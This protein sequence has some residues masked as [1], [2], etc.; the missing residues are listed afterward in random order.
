MVKKQLSCAFCT[1]HM[2]KIGRNGSNG[3]FTVFQFY[4]MLMKQI[5]FVG[6]SLGFH[7]LR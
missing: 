2:K 3:I 7:V 5:Y 4:S 1:K 6:W